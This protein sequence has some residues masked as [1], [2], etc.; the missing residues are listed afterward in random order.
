MSPAGFEL[1]R[2]APVGVPF[3]AS[4][5]SHPE[6]RAALTGRTATSCSVYAR[7]VR[8]MRARNNGEIYAGGPILFSDALHT[9][10]RAAS[11]QYEHCTNFFEACAQAGRC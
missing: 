9:N 6:D 2:H 1:F 11:E 5:L 4:M 8:R 3:T 7:E 10:G